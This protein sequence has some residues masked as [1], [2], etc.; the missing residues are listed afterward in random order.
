[1]LMFVTEATVMGFLG[2]LG[3]VAIG[4][5]GG[6]IFNISINLVAKRFGGE[7]VDLFYSPPAFVLGIIIFAAVVGFL[8]GVVPARRAS[9]IDP[10]DALRYK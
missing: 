9:S 4:Y 1:S 2:G 5:L 6:E 10:L 3:G 7:S 8:T